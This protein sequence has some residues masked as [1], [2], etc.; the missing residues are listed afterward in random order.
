MPQLH[1]YVPDKT[2]K[3]LRS[4]A[5]RRGM[6]LSGY[7]AEVVGR[8]IESDSWPEGFF[9]EVLGGWEGE[10]ERPPQGSYEEREGLSERG[11]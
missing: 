7:L 11:G 6:S 8:E 3:V 9:G 5:E 1:L 10:I 4:R 2:A